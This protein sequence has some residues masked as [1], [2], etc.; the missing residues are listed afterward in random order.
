MIC[1]HTDNTMPDYRRQSAA[2]IRY[3]AHC[4]AGA[5]PRDSHCFRRLLRH[6]AARFTHFI[7]DAQRRAQKQMARRVEAAQRCRCRYV[8]AMRRCYCLMRRHMPLPCRYDYIRSNITA[9]PDDINT[10]VIM[11]RFAAMVPLR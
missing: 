3:S 6:A 2:V 9:S 1:R 5:I 8:A 10:I 7:I 11:P 4:H